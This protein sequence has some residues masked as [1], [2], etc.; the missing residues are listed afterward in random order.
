MSYSNAEIEFAGTVSGA[1]TTSV[2]DEVITMQDGGSNN[3]TVGTLAIKFVTAGIVR[4][5]SEANEHTFSAGDTFN[6]DG[7]A[8][9][10][11]IVKDSGTQIE[12]HGA[13]VA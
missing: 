2:T 1:V 4:I 3:V 6:F 13:I 5:N 9:T 10:Q 11:I 7:I 12:Y 8:I